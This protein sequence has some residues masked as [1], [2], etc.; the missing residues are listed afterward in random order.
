MSNVKTI[1][2]PFEEIRRASAAGGGTTLS[3]TL[4]LISLPIGG[5][6]LT[7]LPRNF[8]TAVV[9]QYALNPW[10]TI[11]ATTD[12]LASKRRLVSG[13]QTIS[14]TDDIS[15]EMQDGD[16]VDFAINAFDTAANNNYIYV[17]S[18]LPFRGAQV[19][20][21]NKNDIA[22]VLTVN[23]WNG[24]WG[25]V[26]TISDGTDV[27][28]D[29]MKQDGDVSW[30]VSSDWKRDSLLNIGDTTV[31]ESWG[32]ASLYWTRWE[33]SVA[34]DTTVDLVTMRALNRS[35]TYAELPEGIVFSEA[36]IAGPNGFS[37]V[38]A[39]VDAGSGNLVVNAATKIGTET[40]FA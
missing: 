2:A 1:E 21:N 40:R 22:S 15:E 37:C 33:V 11:I 5:D 12:A 28:G 19:A 23:Y 13:A 38:E 9:A 36:A 27:S 8:V 39:L 20:L 4:A 17:G 16:S 34:L 35:T 10:L 25:A 31:K 3:T 29:T 7:M 6:W 26:D 24:G 14:E 18:W 30:V 32:G